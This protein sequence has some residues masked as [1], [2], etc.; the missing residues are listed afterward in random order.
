MG[1]YDDIPDVSPNIGD[2]IVSGLTGNHYKV[3]G[4]D[5][6]NCTVNATST[7]GERYLF[8]FDGFEN[9]VYNKV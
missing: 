1:Y 9:G 8:S 6:A 5:Y 2:E 7:G 3:V 4:I